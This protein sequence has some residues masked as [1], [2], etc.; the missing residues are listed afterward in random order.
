MIASGAAILNRV[1]SDLPKRVDPSSR[2]GT[3]SGRPRTHRGSEPRPEQATRN[4]THISHKSL[5]KPH[6]HRQSLPLTPPNLSP[7]PAPRCH[8]AWVEPRA[9]ELSLPAHLC[10]LVGADAGPGRPLARPLSLQI[11]SVQRECPPDGHRPA[12]LAGRQGAA[13]RC[14]Q[15]SAGECQRGNIGKQAEYRLSLSHRDWGRARERAVALAQTD[16]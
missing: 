13:G 7:N 4:S 6:K 15:G 8:L 14:G 5:A 12:R 3:K 9:P 10:G 2:V 11:D 16:R 1:R